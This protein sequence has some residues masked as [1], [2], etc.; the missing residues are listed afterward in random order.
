[1]SSNFPTVV[2]TPQGGLCNRL[3]VL[4]SGLSLSRAAAVSVS[5]E[6]E[7]DDDCRARFDE[8]FEPLDTSNFC[9]CRRHWWARPITRQNLHWPQLVRAVLGWEVQRANYFPAAPEELRSLAERHRKVYVSGG[10]VS[11][12]YAPSLLQELRPLP[13]IQARINAIT[14]EFPEEIVGVHIRRTDNT[15]SRAESEPED[16]VKAMEEE[17]QKHP[18][19]VFFL[20]TDDLAVKKDLCRRFGGKILTLPVPTCRKSVEGIRNAIVDLWCLART[21]RLIGSY[22]SSFTDTAA[23]LGGIPVTIVRKS[24]P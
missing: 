14:R 20:A 18:D 3:R 24:A 11:F 6:W 9:V 16:F 2:L 1:M 19:V 5:V 23:E 21:K 10:S 22:W 4:L 8:L 17:V 12:P 15:V 7:R 13:E